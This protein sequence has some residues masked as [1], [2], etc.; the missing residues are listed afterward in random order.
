MVE[1]ANHLDALADENWRAAMDCEYQAL[2]KNRTWH[3][4]PRPAHCNLIDCKW[5]FK[6]KYR[7]DGSL[8]R[9]QARLVANLFKQCHGVDYAG[10]A[11]SVV[12]R[13]GCVSPWHSQRRCLHEAASWVC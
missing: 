11:L 5:V 1:P 8:D 9:H 2:L 12:G 10:G 13:A 4:V 3:L 6:L 7:A